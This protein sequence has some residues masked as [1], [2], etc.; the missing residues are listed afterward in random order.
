MYAI[1]DYYRSQIAAE[2]ELKRREMSILAPEMSILAPEMSRLVCG[3]GIT[4]NSLPGW[5]AECEC[6]NNLQGSNTICKTAN[7][8]VK[9]RL[10]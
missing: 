7:H 1:V 6:W 2:S 4:D 8:V 5:W 3:D 10:G 9:E